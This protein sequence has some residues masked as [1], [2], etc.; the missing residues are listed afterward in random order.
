MKKAISKYWNR[1]YGFIVGVICTISG[2]VT[3]GLIIGMWFAGKRS[4]EKEK[5]KTE[6]D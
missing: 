4:A 6:E 3:L 2:I 5:D 1:M